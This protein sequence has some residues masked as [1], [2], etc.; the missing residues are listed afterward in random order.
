MTYGCHCWLS[1]VSS[2]SKRDNVHVSVSCR[3]MMYFPTFPRFQYEV[4]L[5]RTLPSEPRRNEVQKVFVCSCVFRRIS[6]RVHTYGL[7]V[8]RKCWIHTYNRCLISAT[9][10]NLLTMPFAI[11]DI[12][13]QVVIC[14]NYGNVSQFWWTLTL[15]HKTALTLLTFI[16]I[17][18]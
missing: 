3:M 18:I 13:Y 14:S 16:V 17:F 10:M 6:V 12:Q 7:F 8:S 11:I 5:I 9:V 15:F 1:Y 2:T 4:P